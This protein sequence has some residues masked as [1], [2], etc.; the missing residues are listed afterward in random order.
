MLKKIVSL[1]REHGLSTDDA[2]CL[3]LAMRLDLPLAT[4]LRRATL[5]Y[6]R[7]EDLVTAIDLPREHGCTHGRDGSR[8]FRRHCG[9]K[10]SGAEL[11]KRHGSRSTVA[12]P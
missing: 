4:C 2:S 1:A 5:K 8:F 10:K 3:D 9:W 7:L 12:S 11:R 6:Q